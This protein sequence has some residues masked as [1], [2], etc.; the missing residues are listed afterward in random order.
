MG[1]RIRNLDEENGGDGKKVNFRNASEQLMS[2][3]AI[4]NRRLK[5]RITNRRTMEGDSDLAVP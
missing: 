2:S 1:K 3:R 5:I 4:P